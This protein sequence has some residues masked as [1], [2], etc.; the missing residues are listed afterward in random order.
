[1]PSSLILDDLPALDNAA[2]RRGRPSNHVAHGEAMALMAAFGLF[3]L[4]FAT[5]AR[6]YDPPLARQLTALVTDAV[7][8]RRADRRRGRGPAGHRVDH[9]VRGARADPPVEDRRIVR[10]RSD[11][12]RAD[13]RRATGPGDRALRL[14]QE[15]RPR[16]PDRR[17]S[18][19]RGRRPGG[20]RQAA[21]GRRAQD[22]LRFV[23]R[24]RRARG[25]SRAN[26][27][28]RPPGRSGFS[29][30]RGSAL[31]ELAG[32]VASRTV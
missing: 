7:G 10:R 28:R 16:V 22:D 26:C 17:R 12:R 27:A 19:R 30:P 25:R 4:A 18:A 1:M 6:A 11:G 8:I 13:S 23:Q 31:R 5:L 24:S 21:A 29:G 9:L 14:R 20:N 32:F 15:P 2:L 3:N